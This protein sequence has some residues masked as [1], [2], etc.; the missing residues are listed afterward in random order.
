DAILHEQ[1]VEEILHERVHCGLLRCPEPCEPGL[2]I[3]VNAALFA[4]LHGHTRRLSLSTGLTGWPAATMTAPTFSVALRNRSAN[5][6]AYL[7]VVLGLLWPRSAPI[8]GKLAPPLTS[9]L[10]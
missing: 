7:A 10:A 2:E 1:F 9:W 5:K 3:D 4:L 6:C 8:S